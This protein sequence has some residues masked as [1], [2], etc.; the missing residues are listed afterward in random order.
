MIH[1]LRLISLIL[2]L[3]G[4]NSIVFGQCTTSV[5]GPF[6]TATFTPQCNQSRNIP[7]TNTTVAQQ[8][9][10]YQYSNINVIAGYQ[11][12]FRSLSSGNAVT[13]DFITIAN[14]TTPIFSG[15]NGSSGI[16]W[17]ATITGVIRFYTHTSA[18]CPTTSILRSREVIMAPFQ[19]KL[20]VINSL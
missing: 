13:T 5:A 9:K 12:N 19:A 4:A 3:A 16:Y 10:T 11:Y 1:Y 18:G 7:P 6:P 14:G 2:F 17:T 15:L 8:L 20:S